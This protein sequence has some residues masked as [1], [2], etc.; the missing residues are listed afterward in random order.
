MYV[1]MILMYVSTALILGSVWALGLGSVLA[2]LIVW[3]TAR[4][5]QTLRQELRGYQEYAAI[6][7]YR[8][9]PGVW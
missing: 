1:A 8:L 7:R 2:V 5:D 6:T 9:L 3:R 4:E